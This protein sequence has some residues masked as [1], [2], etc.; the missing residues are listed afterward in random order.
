MNETASHAVVWRVEVRPRSPAYDVHGRGVLHDLRDYGTT[1]ITEVASS[2]LFLLKGAIDAEAAR[3]IGGE[4]LADPV[5]ESFSCTEGTAGGG[6]ARAAAVEVHLKPGVMDPVA[7]STIA[8]IRDMDL[9]VEAVRTGRRYVIHGAEAVDQLEFVARRI[10]ANDCIEEVFFDG[11]GRHDPPGDVFRQAPARPFVLR[12][13][14]VRDLDDDALR[15]LSREAHLFLSLDEMKAV[16]AHYRDA[17]RDPTDIELEMIAQTWSEHCVHKTLKSAVVYRGEPL[18]GTDAAPKGTTVEIRYD[19]L[20]RD[21]IARAT[22]ELIAE[23][24]SPWCLSVFED[25][26]GVIAFD[27]EYGIAFKVE[28]HNHPSAIE[29]YGGSATGIGGVIR[30]IMGCG[31]GAKPIANTDVFCVGMPDFPIDLL[32]TGVLHPRRI[33]KGV[34]AGVRDYGNRMGIPTVNGAVYFDPRY[35]G[36]PLVFCG[37]VGLIPRRFIRKR[38]NPGDLVVVVGGRTGRDGIHGATFSSAELTDSHADEF[39]HAVQIGNAITEKKVLD[40]QLQAR[41]HADGCLYTACT[42]CGAGGLSSAVGE[43]GAEIGAVVDLEKVPLKYAGLRYDEIWISEAQERMVL[44]VPPANWPKV[45][46]IFDA[47]GVEA[48]AIGTFGNNARLVMRYDGKVVG[49]ISAEFLHHGIPKTQKTA[50]WRAASSKAPQSPKRERGADAVDYV[51]ELKRRL[52]D[53]NNASKEW[54]IRQYDHEVQGGSAVKPLMGPHAGPSD[55]AVIR[56]RLDSNRGIAI[57]CGLCP[58]LADIDPY[59]MAVHAIDEAIRN[60][61]CVGGDPART[62]I[63]DN[64]CWGNC[65]DPEVMGALVRACQGCY[66]AAKAYGVPFISGKDSLNNEFALDPKDA[67]RLREYLQ[68]R[69]IDLANNRLRIPST[70]LISAISMID[71]VTK[72]VTADAKTCRNKGK[73]DECPFWLLGVPLQGGIEFSLEKAAGLHREVHRLIREGVVLAAH[74]FS[75]EGFAA[76]MAEM[77]IGGSCNVDVRLDGSPAVLAD[78]FAPWASAYV[79]QS[80]DYGLLYKLA[81]EASLV[82]AEVGLGTGDTPAELSVSRCR[83]VVEGRLPL[84]GGVHRLSTGQTVARVAMAELREA[85]RAPL[86]W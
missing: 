30:D 12:H 16:Q 85:W 29:P 61:V 35:M 42:D 40:T 58:H 59:W 10:L 15:K 5:T 44:A 47:E 71:D 75:E 60:V 39:S 23:G 2:R 70:L 25:N 43:M 38:A 48:T 1:S 76:C 14:A 51:T 72:C 3:R 77:A 54:I 57:G 69:S 83:T 66:D 6:P 84:V 81:A 52:S 33:L 28:T 80:P 9:D 22:H 53:L 8:A 49:D 18:P 55:A 67:A 45:K 73:V 31:N 13:V 11:L 27:D 41:D 62:A 17:G 79:L 78:P 68:A 82:V 19:N 74:D 32:P 7:A 56:P 63:L 46:A 24:K 26:A 4:L 36:N 65:E 37:C 20:L 21:T 64:F 50:A 86:R 34:V